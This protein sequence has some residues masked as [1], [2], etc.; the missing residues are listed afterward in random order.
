MKINKGIYTID[1]K[2]GGYYKAMQFNKYLFTEDMDYRERFLN[3]LNVHPE[4]LT[5]S[6]HSRALTVRNN[7]HTGEFTARDKTFIVLDK[8]G[9]FIDN[10]TKD[11]LYEMER[12]LN[13]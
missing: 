13:K 4:H 11:A 1:S 8:S 5:I 3:F 6:N 12:I 9:K 2:L 7:S 10:C